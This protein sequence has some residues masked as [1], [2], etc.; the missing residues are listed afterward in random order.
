MA[1]AERQI[2]HPGVEKERS[3]INFHS[4]GFVTATMYPEW[5][6]LAEGET[7]DPKDIIGVR[8]DLALQTIKKAVQSGF[9]VVVVDNPRSSDAFKSKLATIEGIHTHQETATTMSGGR[10]QGFEAT[11][12]LKGVKVIAWAEP[13]K[14]S[15]IDHIVDTAAPIITGKADIV[16][17]KRNRALFEAKYPDYQLDFETRANERFNNLLRKTGLRTTDEDFDAWFGPRLI[18]NDSEVL[19]HFFQV[20]TFDNTDH[21]KTYATT[22]PEL[23]PDALF[24]PVPA[25]L[26]AGLRVASVEVDYE[27]PTEQTAVEQDSPELRTKRQIQYSGI[28]FSTVHHL[29]RE[30]TDLPSRLQKIV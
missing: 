21:T 4:I 18:K 5:K 2:N 10:R 26:K 29:K 11:S 17:P 14:L 24:L 16:I 28:I 13:E 27:H 23:W 6:Q 8:G 1:I 15:M 25:A 9:Q 22:D 12:K 19:K 7:R 20:N 3:P 30:I